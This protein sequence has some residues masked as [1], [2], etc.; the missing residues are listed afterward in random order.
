MA[1]VEKSVLVERSSQQMFDLVDDVE[2]YPKFLPWCSQTRVGFRD[3]KKT[4]ATLHINFMTVKSHFTTENEK[5][6][7]SQMI[8]KLVDGPFRQLEG[9]WS[10]KPLAENACKIDLRLSYEFSSKIIEKIIGPV[11]SQITNTFV[12]AFVKRADD[13]YGVINV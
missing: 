8:I 11:F 3:E 9:V 2:S 6:I 13:V 5:N 12:D 10:F 7:P 1:M 4:I